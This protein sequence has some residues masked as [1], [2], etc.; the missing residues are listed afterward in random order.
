VSLPREAQI[1]AAVLGM[2]TP[3][4]RVELAASQLAREGSTPAL[5]ALCERIRDAVGDL[6]RQI[7]LSLRALLPEP[8]EE[9]RW[10]PCQEVIAE[11][12][13]RFR[14][15]LE[16]RGCACVEQVASQE[17]VRGE[18]ER[19]RRAT[20]CLLRASGAVA[21]RGGRV[22][23]GAETEPGRYGISV[24]VAQA[25]VE[26]DGGWT[27]SLEQVLE[28]TRAFALAHDAE[29]DVRWSPASGSSLLRAT[30]WFRVPEA[31]A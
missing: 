27:E 12:V 30:L 29:L 4:A 17:P 1:A 24:D 19:V 28:S 14:P 9:G 18:R 31:D 21:S 6:D 20:L 16:A 26:V 10:A 25:N 2:R 3:L 8:Q 11:V 23:L 22:R 15:V 13:D 5:A 7:E